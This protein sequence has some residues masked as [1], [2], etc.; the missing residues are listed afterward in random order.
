MD[1]RVGRL[2]SGDESILVEIVRHHKS[3]VIEIDHATRLLANPLNFHHHGG[4]PE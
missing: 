4:V 1:I 3:R 2:S